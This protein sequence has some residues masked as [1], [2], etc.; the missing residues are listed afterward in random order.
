MMRNLNLVV[1]LFAFSGSF[2]SRKMSSENCLFCK[3]ITGSSP[4]KICFQDEEIIAFHDIKPASKNHILVVP[5]QHIDNVNALDASNISLVEKMVDC[6][7]SV[8]GELQ[9]DISDVRFGF[10]RPPFNSIK[11]LHLHCI[12]PMSQMSFTQNLIFRPNT[13]WFTTVDRALDM[14]KSKI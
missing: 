12:S 7:K 5:K 4:A 3:I 11:H 10:H 6:G 8:L 2:Q 1:R 14:M 9:A 13:W